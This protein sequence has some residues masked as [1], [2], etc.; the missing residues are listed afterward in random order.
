MCRDSFLDEHG[1]R[2][3]MTELRERTEE[4][5][6]IYFERTRDAEIA[7]M[8]PQASD[9]LEAALEAYRKTLLP[10]AMS[11]GRTIYQD[12]VYIGDVWC[13]GMD[14]TETP[15]AM[16]GYCIFEK[17]HWNRGIATEALRLF[18]EQLIKRFPIKSLGAFAYCSNA[19]SLRVLEKN[20][21]EQR[22]IFFEDGILSAYYEK[23]KP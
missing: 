12:G 11:W 13:Y 15:N 8:L 3:F 7:A 6:R 21:F 9:S 20:G 10:G 16:L 14:E 17:S 19:A 5:V 23:S 2:F 1:E 4:H 22:E 18:A